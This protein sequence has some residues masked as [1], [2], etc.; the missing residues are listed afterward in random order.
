M[1]AG[2]PRRIK[3]QSGSLESLAPNNLHCQQSTTIYV[4]S[5][6]EFLKLSGNAFCVYEFV[7]FLVQILKK[8]IEAI[9]INNIE[10]NSGV[11]EPRCAF[12]RLLQT[13]QVHHQDSIAAHQL[14][15]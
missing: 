7:K 14:T 3:Y 6:H 13:S 8:I 2:D 5:L 11:N 9:L 12:P 15:A 4:N 1:E 10:V